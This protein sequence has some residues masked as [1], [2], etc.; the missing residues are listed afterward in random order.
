MSY[1][2]S[3]PL[4]PENCPAGTVLQVPC[5]VMDLVPYKH[6][7]I[8]DGDGHVISNSKEKGKVICQSLSAFADGKRVTINSAFQGGGG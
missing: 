8:T 6:M 5:R 1:D 3:M 2:L 4:S 7:G